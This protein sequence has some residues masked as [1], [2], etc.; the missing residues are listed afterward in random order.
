MARENEAPVLSLA[1]QVRL[2]Q[3]V[4]E[5]E[6]TVEHLTAQL[7]QAQQQLQAATA[8]AAPPPAPHEQE[9]T[10]AHCDDLEQCVRE[11]SAVVLAQ[12]NAALHATIAE[13]RRT[14]EV[15]RSTNDLL[16]LL[17]S[18]IHIAIAYLDRDFTFIRVNQAYAAADNCDPSFF[19]G[20]NHF[21]LY[22]DA[23][24][25]VLFRQV[26]ESGETCTAYAKPFVYPHTPERGITYWDWTLQPVFGAEGQVT[27]LLFCL[28]NVTHQKQVEQ[29]LSFQSH[30]LGVIGQAVI[31]TNREG[32]ITYW[33]H[34]AEQI[35]GWTAEEA[36]GR[37]VMLVVN[38][39][40]LQPAEE[41]LSHLH[42]GAHWSG[43]FMV[44]RRDGS[45]FPALVTNVPFYDEDGNLH[46]IVG[47]SSD[48]SERKA[49]EEALQARER[50]LQ[51]L[52]DHVPASIFVKDT[53]QRYLL[54]NH[55]Y[56]RL[57]NLERDAVVGKTNE[58]ILAYMLQRGIVDVNSDTHTVYNQIVNTW[59]A[60][61][62][63]VLANGSM[64]EVEDYVPI[65]GA[66][67]S[68]LALKFPIYDEHG[69]IQ[70]IG[71]FSTDITERRRMEENLQIK[72]NAIAS[73]INAIAFADPTGT[74]TSV[75]AAF[76][77][78]WGYDHEDDV[79]GKQA[80]SFW[81]I[82]ATAQEVVQTLY[83]QGYW[84]GEMVAQRKD[85]TCFDAQLSA[86]LISETT[87]APVTMM[88]S[89]VDITE[90]KRME[91]ALRESEERFKL[92][93]DSADLGL[94]DWNVQTG[95][96]VFNRRWCEM[97]GYRQEEITPH[98][99]TWERLVHPDD[100]AAVTQ[101][102][103]EHLAGVTPVYV[104]EHRLRTRDGRWKWIQDYG[105]V[106]ERD[107]EGTPLRMLGT[108]R[109]IDAQK[110]YEA[111]LRQARDAAEAATRAKSE[112]LANMSHEIRTPMNAIIGMASLLLD[113]DMDT[114]QQESVQ[115]ILSSSNALLAIINDILDLS[116]IEAGRINLEYHSFT[117]RE[118]IEG[119]LD[120]LAP[121]AAEQGL[122]L[123]YQ[124]ADDVPDHLVGDLMRL[125]QII[126]NL[127]SNAVKFTRQGEVVVSIGGHAT[128]DSG[129][130]LSISVRDT[131]I[132]IAP[133][134]QAQLFQPFSQGDSSTTRRYGGSGLGLA[135][136]KRLAELMGGRIGVESTPGH[137]S[138]F[139]V[140]LQLEQAA[141]ATPAST[142]WE[143]PVLQGKSVLIVASY[144]LHRQLLQRY[145]ARWGMRALVA[146]S[147]SEALTV[148]RQ[149]VH[150]DVALLDIPADDMDGMSHAAALHTIRPPQQL[151]LI[152]WVS[153]AQRRMIRRQQEE[154]GQP[155]P[156][157]LAAMLLKPMRPGALAA[158]LRTIVQQEKQ[159]P[160]P[161]SDHAVNPFMGHTNPLRI[162]L[163][164]DNRL[165]QRVALRFLE[166]MGYC[167]DIAVTGVEVLEALQQHRYDLV[168]MDV[169]MPEMD[170]IEATRRI[171]AQWPAE[172][173]PHIIAMTAHAMEGDREWCLSVGMDDYIGKPIHIETLVD[174]LKLVRRISVD[175]QPMRQTEA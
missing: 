108:H 144:A 124:I 149:P 8:P 133:E 123:L 31:A 113:S 16:E 143:Q 42:T 99:S 78:M 148:L 59:D 1:E 75:N 25:E 147:I 19:V 139:Y 60:Q 29:R 96:V 103:Q 28:I 15:L 97:I 105:K 18:S 119:A 155:L 157:E 154:S 82:P 17:F 80:I 126:I 50:L 72:S 57:I 71:G 12:M 173:Q 11:E 98:V 26:V 36:L 27:G 152:V 134:H 49:M 107:A 111:E 175:T 145:A 14:E 174:R 45:L 167:A 125:R 122:E 87:G 83:A 63:Q 67:R 30:L 81:Q 132:G 170:G 89:F 128:G 158:A 55:Y 74:L 115:A 37:S 41:I 156:T 77:R 150:F 141:A 3:R 101:I 161:A 24:N 58:E 116:R 22:P 38:Q 35:Y 44:Q 65:D 142:L 64:L 114:E 79:L 53:R 100:L 160:H 43:E 4:A 110:H 138:T 153:V 10:F 23:E 84:T 85:G 136:C 56:Q 121:R 13:Q 39:R 172:Q 76:L 46:G 70:G 51:T 9:T 69:T 166:R 104:T 127:V 91:Q 112:F 40:D 21:D 159:E 118:S 20:K 109:D 2:Q 94:W 54:I 146:T 48:I 32:T 135:I 61:D 88:A 130:E 34:A 90:R 93:L 171:R 102:L 164:E 129:Y 68:Y 165:N 66:L 120:M 73:A 47:I 131:G 7:A 62:Q 92:S 163:A 162:L 106:V 151:P 137:G 95:E 6:Q 117:L 52:I 169:Q 140:T 86:T 5:L 33:N 168:L